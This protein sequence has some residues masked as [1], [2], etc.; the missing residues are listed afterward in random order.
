MQPGLIFVHPVTGFHVDPVHSI[1]DKWPIMPSFTAVSVDI[2]VLLRFL[3]KFIA[4][5]MPAEE[6]QVIKREVLIG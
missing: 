3:P 5:F 4:S 2:A 6:C 1:L